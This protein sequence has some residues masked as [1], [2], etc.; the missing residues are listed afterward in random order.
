MVELLTVRFR[1]RRTWNRTRT[2]RFRFQ[3]SWLLY[4]LVGSGSDNCITSRS[5]F[6]EWYLWGP[7]LFRFSA[8]ISVLNG[9][10]GF[11]WVLQA[12]SSWVQPLGTLFPP[13]S[14]WDRARRA[15]IR[16]DWSLG[17]L[18]IKSLT[19]PDDSLISLFKF[20]RADHP[21]IVSQRAEV[22]LVGT[23]SSTE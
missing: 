17:S 21:T 4:N 11:N 12:D 20:K 10:S 7:R 19:Y 23:P 22:L 1:D 16:F 13:E 8:V 14:R 6:W 9:H 3:I 2:V 5:R 15:D 18:E